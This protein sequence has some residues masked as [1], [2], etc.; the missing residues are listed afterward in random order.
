MLYVALLEKVGSMVLVIVWVL[1]DVWTYG[2][3]GIRCSCVYGGKIRKTW[4]YVVLL[5]LV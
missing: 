3:I 5:R 1:V 4:R 2:G